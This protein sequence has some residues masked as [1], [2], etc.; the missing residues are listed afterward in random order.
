[1][2]WGL[3]FTV[4]LTAINCI[5]VKLVTRVQD[6]FTVAKVIALISIIATG[7]VLLCTG[8]IFMLCIYFIIIFVVIPILLRGIVLEVFSPSFTF[9]FCRQSGIST[10]LWEHIW[11]IELEH[12][13]GLAGLLLGPVHLPGL[14]L[15]ELYCRG[16]SKPKTV[17]I[18]DDNEALIFVC[19]LSDS[20]SR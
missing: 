11:W 18:C 15:F 1:M 7:C 8:K 6:F 3:C 17:Q 12:R 5:S 20:Q 4:L 14:E 10:V 19:V 16:A 2:S 9:L 13:R